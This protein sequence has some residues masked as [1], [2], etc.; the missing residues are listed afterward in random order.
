MVLFYRKCLALNSIKPD[1]I[2]SGTSQRL[3]LK[4]VSG[5]ISVNIADR[6]IQLRSSVRIFGSTLKCNHFHIWPHNLTSRHMHVYSFCHIRSFMQFLTYTSIDE[7][8][9]HFRR[10]GCDIIA[11]LL[12][13][14]FY[15]IRHKADLRQI[16]IDFLFIPAKN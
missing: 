9:G 2:L 15:L 11:P 4:P 10:F 14:P 3:R 1:V 6:E 13:C 7:S 12:M 8:N 5:F 16:I